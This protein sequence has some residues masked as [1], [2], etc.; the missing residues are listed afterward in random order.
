MRERGYCAGR[1][2]ARRRWLATVTGRTCAGSLIQRWKP[3]ERSTGPKTPE[4]KA[5]VSRNAYKGGTRPLLRELARLL[6]EQKSPD[7]R[8][9]AWLV[10]PCGSLERP[11]YVSTAA[12][13]RQN[14]LYRFTADPP[15]ELERLAFRV[16]IQIIVVCRAETQ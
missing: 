5:R 12:D 16:L 4:G 15:I 1:M 11:R 14:L 13:Q 8:V 3:W 6:R 9:R 7:R 2:L 10:E